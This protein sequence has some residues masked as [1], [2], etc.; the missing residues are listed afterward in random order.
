MADYRMLVCIGIQ[1]H[2]ELSSTAGA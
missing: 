2:A 1:S